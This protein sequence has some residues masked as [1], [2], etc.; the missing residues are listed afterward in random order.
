MGGLARHGNG[1]VRLRTDRGFGNSGGYNPRSPDV[2]VA[3]NSRSPRTGQTTARKRRARIGV[4]RA[5][6]TVL[7]RADEVNEQTRCLDFTY[8]R[9][10]Q[11]M[12]LKPDRTRQKGGCEGQKDGQSQIGKGA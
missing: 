9:G 3:V 2:V 1:S 4:G 11:D 10:I 7:G 12:Q 6:D 5:C 8:H